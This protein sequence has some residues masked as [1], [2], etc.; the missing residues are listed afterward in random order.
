[1][2]GPN[3]FKPRFNKFVAMKES[4]YWIFLGI[5]LGILMYLGDKY[6]F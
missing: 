2:K 5:A 3:Y 1:M 6:I 4:Y